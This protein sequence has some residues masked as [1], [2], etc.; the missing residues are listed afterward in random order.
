M[1]LA[2]IMGIPILDVLINLCIPR[3]HNSKSLLHNFIGLCQCQVMIVT[4]IKK[5]KKSFLHLSGHR[6]PHADTDRRNSPIMASV[7]S[8][9]SERS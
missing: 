7:L 5:E 1:Y 9:D 8:Y 4:K 6:I 2:S 3:Y